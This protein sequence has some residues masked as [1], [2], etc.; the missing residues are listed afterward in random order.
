VNDVPTNSCILLATEEAARAYPTGDIRLCFCEDC[1]FIF[2][3]AFDSRKTEY[4]GCYEETQGFSGVFSDFHK[5]LAQRLIDK[6]DL[7]DKDVL[8]IG[9]GKG[10]FLM[11]L[12]EFGRNRGVGIDPGVRIERLSGE[13]ATRLKFIQDFYSEKHASQK[14]DFVACK[15]TLEHIPNASDFIGSIRRGLGAQTD[16]IVFFQ[17]PETGRILRTCAF[18]D[19]YYEHC[20]Y[21]TKGAL[22][23]LFRRTGFDVLDVGIEYGDQYLTIEARPSSGPPG[24]PPAEENDL[25]EMRR[26]VA[27][28]SERCG[29]A[30]NNWCERLE[31]FNRDG[32]TVALWGSG[33]KAVSFLTTLGVADH[34]QFVTDINP[35]R[36]GHFLPKT[37]HLIISPEKLA[38][39]GPDVVIVMNA[40]YRNEIAGSLL[41][42]GAR[43]E[44]LTL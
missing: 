16:T 14:V 39:A 30:L 28:F 6:Y 22:A 36:H 5:A 15:M 12:S 41:K 17:I 29:F 42:L 18:E 33:S 13:A 19:I 34:V 23:R 4:S 7:Y 20:S 35:Y 32:K 43:C 21:Y 25:D 8:E 31:R 11:L 26:L 44:V 37:A 27:S 3:S 38:Q 1:G 10:E 9:C 24:T 2:N 40:I